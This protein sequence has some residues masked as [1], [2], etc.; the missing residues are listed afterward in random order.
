[1]DLS[2]TIVNT[3]HLDDTLKCLR[4]IYDTADNI[5]F[6]IYVVNNA[7]T[8]SSEKIIS[9]RFPQVYLI[10]NKRPH[11]VSANFN[12]GFKRSKGR[13][14]LMLNEDCI[15]AD[16]CLERMVEF[17]DE[18]KAVGVA[19]PQIL[20]P[21]KSLQKQA[22]RFLTLSSEF[23]TSIKTKAPFLKVRFAHEY[24]NSMFRK[25]FEPD[26]VAGIAMF[27]RKEILDKIGL[28]D[29]R[30]FI[31]CEDMDICKRIRQAGWNA[32]Y[33]TPAKIIHKRWTTKKTIEAS[34]AFKKRLMHDLL[35][36]RFKYFRKHFKKSDVLIL[37]CVIL[38]DV[39]A[40]LI[41]SSLLYI[42]SKNSRA[43]FPILLDWLKLTI[44][45]K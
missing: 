3:N 42:F 7:C 41:K 40:R 27:F 25:T 15:V 14:L 6:E 12:K 1:M 19:S 26:W 21:D 11:G 31:F 20:N 35:E 30:F 24:P 9:E 34:H 5:S 32:A 44:T 43:A 33:F 2:I 29:E 8:D 39:T 28:F 22:Y 38:F 16:G 10:N 23:I 4:S 13:Y 17:L 37:K 36:S 18:N 45:L